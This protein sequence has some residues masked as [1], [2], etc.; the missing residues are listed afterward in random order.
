MRGIASKTIHRDYW[1]M[2]DGEQPEIG[3]RYFVAHVA[4][5]SRGNAQANAVNSTDLAWSRLVRDQEDGGS[6]PLAPTT[7]FRISDLQHTKIRRAS[8]PGPGSRCF[9]SISA[10]DSFPLRSMG[11][12]PFSTAS[13][14]SFYGQ[15]GQLMWFCLE[16]GTLSLA[17]CNIDFLVGSS[18]I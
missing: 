9:K 15:R 3:R 17:V 1:Y 18:P 14:I 13:S 10:D 8:G 12:A 2:R 7:L 16:F 5:I 11:Y 6:N 4:Q